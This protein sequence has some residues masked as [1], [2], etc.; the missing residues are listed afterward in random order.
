MRP[1]RFVTAT[2]VN[3]K[4]L[5]NFWDKQRG[6]RYY[7]TGWKGLDRLNQVLVRLDGHGRAGWCW[8]DW[9]VLPIEAPTP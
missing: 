9:C 1:A 7:H 4:W 8:F 2:L 5:V 3:D 6:S